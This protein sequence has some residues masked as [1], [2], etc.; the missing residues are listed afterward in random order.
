[1]FDLHSFSRRQAFMVTIMA[2]MLASI[3]AASKEPRT[4]AS[5]D[6][7]A[8]ALA[9]AAKAMDQKSIIEILGPSYA[10][11]IVS[12][13]DVFDSQALQ[14]FV[15]AYSQKHVVVPSGQD[16]SLLTVG[17]DDFPFPF[18]VV[19]R[20]GVW[21]FDAEAGKDELL[22]RRIGQNELN[23]IE[24]L[25]AVVDAQ[26]DYAM[27]DRDDNGAPDYATKFISTPGKR[28]G[29]YWPAARGEAESPL[30][31]LV[32]EA[33]RKGYGGR[34]TK[35]EPKPYD[36]YYFKLLLGQGNDAEGGAYD[37]IVRG[38][39]IGGFAVLAYPARYGISGIKSF[40]V[41][42]DG[43]VYESD[44]GP[45]SPTAAEKITKFNPDKNWQK[46]ASE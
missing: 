3:P 12:G 9:A 39:M 20:R 13:D 16:K 6:E 11:W 23:T 33:V 32:G 5:P 44:L 26:R 24:V 15:N 34:G 42:H 35:D 29:L 4:F 40:M 45:S 17:N 46:A 10:E 19:N 18:P 2:G 41:S 28:D 36:G 31:P 22:S 25:R 27:R 43:V 8:S 1:M 30:G 38:K 37:Y 21:T 7:A 14:R